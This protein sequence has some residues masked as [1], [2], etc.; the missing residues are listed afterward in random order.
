MTAQGSVLSSGT[1]VSLTMP[2]VAGESVIDVE[3]TDSSGSRL[4]PSSVTFE[5][6]A[7]GSEDWVDLSTDGVDVI[8]NGADNSPSHALGYYGT[9]GTSNAIIS[10]R[11]YF[12]RNLVPMATF[13]VIRSQAGSLPWGGLYDI[14]GDWMP[15]HCGHRDGLTFDLSLRNL[16]LREKQALGLA[17][18]KAGLRFF[19]VPE[20][21][22]NRSANHWHAAL[23]R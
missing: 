7:S 22:L 17:S 6:R 2:E 3:G 19:Y 20:S 14:D 13:P 16:S 11:N 5:V 9:E 21:P 1:L 12:E 15:P 18:S 8:V 4:E 10:M 23:S